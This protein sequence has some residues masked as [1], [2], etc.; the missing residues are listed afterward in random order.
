MSLPQE[1]ITRRIEFV[2][3]LIADAIIQNPSIN[4]EVI[5]KNQKT[6]RNGIVTIGT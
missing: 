1:E 3:D 4:S 5:N 6:I 2:L